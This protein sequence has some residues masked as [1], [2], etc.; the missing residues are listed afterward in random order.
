MFSQFEPESIW[1]IV[2]IPWWLLRYAFAWCWFNL[3]VTINIVKYWHIKNHP[4]IKLLTEPGTG[5][6][7]SPM[8]FMCPRCLWA[9]PVR[10]MVHTYCD[11]G[12]GE[13]VEPIDECPR[14]GWGI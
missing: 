4:F 14:C 9:G 1:D 7:D 8:P 12:S 5:R 13:D 6:Q 11:D 3:C 2:L 10:W